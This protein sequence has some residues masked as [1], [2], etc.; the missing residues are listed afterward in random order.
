MDKLPLATMVALLLASCS[1]VGGGHHHPYF[2]DSAGILSHRRAPG[3][4]PAADG[5][6]R[7]R[8]TSE[9]QGSWG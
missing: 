5:L 2:R 7:D 6:H 9:Y 8:G 1:T 4:M 3:H